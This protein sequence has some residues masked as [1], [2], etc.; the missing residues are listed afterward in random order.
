MGTKFVPNP[1]FAAEA[2]ESIGVPMAHEIGPRVVAK[3]KDFAP[4]DSGELK[5][6]IHAEYEM[7][8][9]PE[10]GETYVARII[11]DAGHALPQEVGWSTGEAQ[12]Y[13]RPAL[14]EVIDEL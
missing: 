8:N 12:P 13:L 9:H 3:A 14:I 2:V 11:A 5:E 4:V 10:V 1:F 6:S 7:E